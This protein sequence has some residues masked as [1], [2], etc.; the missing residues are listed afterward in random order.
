MTSVELSTVLKRTTTEV[1]GETSCAPS[2]GET[3]STAGSGT[4]VNVRL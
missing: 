3:D 1:S 4:T 2:T